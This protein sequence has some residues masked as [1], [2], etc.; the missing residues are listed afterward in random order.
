MHLR[1]SSERIIRTYFVIHGERKNHMHCGYVN[2]TVNYHGSTKKL[3]G[4]ILN[5][6]V[7]YLLEIF[8][9]LNFYTVTP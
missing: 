4:Y 5:E 1:S 9:N 2:I 6:I 8:R 3:C 7:F